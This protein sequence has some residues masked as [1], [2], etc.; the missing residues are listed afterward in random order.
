VCVL[1][2]ELPI[3]IDRLFPLEKNASR[4]VSSGGFLGA[5]SAILS[6][7]SLSIVGGWTK[8]VYQTS[9]KS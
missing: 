3:F 1:C 2:I 8:V 9:A 7:L 4:R 6:P 5:G